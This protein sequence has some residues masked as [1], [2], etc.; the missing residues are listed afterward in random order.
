MV[1]SAL[2]FGAG[3]QESPAPQVVNLSSEDQEDEIVHLSP[4]EIDASDDVGYRSTNATSGTSLN[5]P[6]R[7]IPMSI[8]VINRV[9]L[10]DT[11][12]IGVDEALQ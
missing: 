2:A 3:A 12:A 10:D 6:I 11:G 8:E 1:C 5:T 7:D 9:F 4:F